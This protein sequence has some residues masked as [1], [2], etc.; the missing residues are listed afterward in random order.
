M[1]IRFRIDI[2]DM[3]IKKVR[4]LATGYK[5]ALNAEGA[6]ANLSFDV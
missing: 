6:F 5:S 3:Q 1:G 2:C 4:V